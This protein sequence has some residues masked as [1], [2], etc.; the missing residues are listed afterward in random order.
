MGS[1]LRFLSF[2]FPAFLGGNAPFVSS[3]PLTHGESMWS[4]TSPNSLVVY[5]VKLW[6]GVWN[7]LLKNSF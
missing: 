7:G 5:V 3:P 1:S 6:E 2:K 4:I